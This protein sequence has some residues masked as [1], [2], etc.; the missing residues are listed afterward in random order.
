MTAFLCGAA[1][2]RPLFHARAAIPKREG[3][4][5]VS[6]VP[7]LPPKTARGP[8]A[9][10]DRGQPPLPLPGEF[11]RQGALMLGCNELIHHYPDVF[12]D[13]V[14]ATCRT[15]P[16]I[17]LISHIDQKQI[18][19]ELFRKH[20]LPTGAVQ[21]VLLPLDSM[22]VRD[23]GP[24]FMRRRD[25][26]AYAVEGGY[27]QANPLKVKRGLDDEAANLLCES[28]G[29]PVVSVPLEFEGGNLLSNGE[30]LCVTSLDL[31]RKNPRFINDKN[32]LA[33]LLRDYF[34]VR[35]WVHV[36]SLKGEPTRHADMFVTFV[37]P[38]VAVVGQYDPAYDPENAAILDQTAELL[39]RMNTSRGP[40]KVHRIP[41]PPREGK[42]W[43]TYT[44][45]LFANGTLLMPTFSGVD[46]A[47]QAEAMALYARLLPGWKVVGVR[48][49]SLHT[50][51]GLLHC[52]AMNVPS[53]VKLWE[54]K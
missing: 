53:F 5:A 44:N 30:G 43:R 52:V 29:L 14:A 1:F 9:T 38:D 47:M 24:L 40:M 8:V 21:F 7:G 50:S 54:R 6:T 16:L 42:F 45:V 33:R 34:G 51:E 2:G 10:L 48:A 41:M 37:A 4:S 13:I 39:S 26:T 15:T 31:I 49:D 28:L 36:R 12:V 20:G 22:W 27:F 23:Y 17:G 19:L 3:V 32:G 35:A 25:G 46:P 11:Q 18:A